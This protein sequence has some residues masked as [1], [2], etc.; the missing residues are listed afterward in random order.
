MYVLVGY[1]RYESEI[2]YIYRLP[3][4]CGR[5]GV[6]YNCSKELKC[7]VLVVAPVLAVEDCGGVEDKG[8]GGGVVAVGG[9]G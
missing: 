6:Y 7:F 4:Y 2:I 3:Y 8:I 1:G 9:G 5:L